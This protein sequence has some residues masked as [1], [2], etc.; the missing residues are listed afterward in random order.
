MYKTKPVRALEPQRVFNE[1]ISLRL[2]IKSFS[3]YYILVLF[4]IN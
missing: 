3:Y 4:R 2:L 1:V